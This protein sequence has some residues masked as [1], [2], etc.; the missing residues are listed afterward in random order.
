M[1]NRAHIFATPTPNICSL[2][3]S[4]ADA[5]VAVKRTI[6]EFFTG[7]GNRITTGFS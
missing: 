5:K 2:F 1:E 7:G 4:I 6:C 3:V